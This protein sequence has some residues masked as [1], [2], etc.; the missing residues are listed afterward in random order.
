M[1]FT[2]IHA[3][4]NSTY[5]T[6]H[7][8]IWLDQLKIELPEMG[9]LRCNVNWQMSGIR[10]MLANLPAEEP[11]TS[12]T[13]W[14]FLYSYFGNGAKKKL[15]ELKTPAGIL[16]WMKESPLEVLKVLGIDLSPITR[17]QEQ[18]DAANKPKEETKAEAPKKKTKERNPA[19]DTVASESVAR[20][21]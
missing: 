17:S 2:D 9:I 6:T 14:A 11:I 1:N 7:H 20:A 19:E 21:T 8:R 18:I 16:G 13:A 10:T 4:N 12:K 3:F 15:Q 5:S